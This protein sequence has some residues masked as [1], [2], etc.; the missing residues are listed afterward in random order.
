MSWII[1]F[2]KMLVRA[3]RIRVWNAQISYLERL[4]FCHRDRWYLNGSEERLHFLDPKINKDVREGYSSALFN[5]RSGEIYIGKNVMF[6][7][8]VQI[9]AGRHNDT[10]SDPLVFKETINEGFDVKI[11]DGV[12]LTSRVIVIGGVTIGDNVTVLPGSVVSKDLPSNCVAGGIP[13]RVISY[14]EAVN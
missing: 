11:G 13:S 3:I 12:W 7:H 1:G 4:G 14:K 8:D 5:T 2:I 6:G 10:Y 9:L